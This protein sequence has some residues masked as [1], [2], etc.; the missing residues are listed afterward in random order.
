MS[1][2]T[3]RSRTSFRWGLMRRH[4]AQVDGETFIWRRQI[5]Q[6]PWFAVLLTRI[7]ATD[8]RDPHD[9][10]R[11]FVSFILRGGYTELVYPDKDDLSVVRERTHRRWSI[12]TLRHI[13]A[14]RIIKIEHPLTTFAVC[15][16]M[17][18]KEFTFWTPEGR[19]P[20]PQY[21]G[22]DR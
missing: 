7:G 15:G 3:E 12:H 18:V 8:S 13:E 14:H 10:S 16:R 4:W 17:Q 1:G 22:N 21:W 9:H 2:K 19:V 11:S 6:C 5:V 20:W